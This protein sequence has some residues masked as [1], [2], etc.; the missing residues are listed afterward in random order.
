MSRFRNEAFSS[1]VVLAH[2]FMPVMHISLVPKPRSRAIKV[3]AP[4]MIRDRDPRSL[5][6]SID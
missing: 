3:V 2:N 5:L 1:V 4:F 6:A